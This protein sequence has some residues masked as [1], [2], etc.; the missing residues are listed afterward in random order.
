MR[1]DI[2]FDVICP[3]CLI[4][5][6]RLENALE[7]RRDVHAA[8]RWHPFQLNPAMP[9]GGMPRRHYLDTKFGGPARARQIYRVVEDTAA[10]DGIEMHINRIEMTPNT[11]DAHRLIRWAGRDAS[12]EPLIERLFRAYFV[13]GL[14]IGD[15]GVLAEMA[16]EAGQDRDAA[17]VFL[18]GDADRAD[19][20]AIDQAARQMGIQGVPCFVFDGAYAVSGAQEPASFF[21]IFDL[22]LSGPRRAPAAA[23]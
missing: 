7:Q 15:H 16:A 2:F 18:A 5:K 22:V 6:R 19:V 14:D 1:I 4:G 9:Q 8:L 21:P 23:G 12:P 3:W 20:Q 10:R 13:E 11:L 17:A